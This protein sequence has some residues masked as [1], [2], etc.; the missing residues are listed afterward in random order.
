MGGR[1]Y[2]CGRCGRRAAAIVLAWH[3]LRL[4]SGKDRNTLRNRPC[5]II[6]SVVRAMEKG[7][8]VDAAPP[9]S[10]GERCR[11]TVRLKR[12]HGTVNAHGFDTEAWLLE[13]GLRATGYVRKDDGNSTTRRVR[14]RPSDWVERARERI[15]TRTR[16]R[17][18]A[19]LPDAQ[20]TGV[21]VALTVGD[22]R[23]IPE[24]Q[25]KVFSRTGIEIASL[26]ICPQVFI[27]P[28]QSRFN[29]CETMLWDEYCSS[30]SLRA[31]FE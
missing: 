13:N 24:S 7:I 12:P 4:R 23:A 14:R 16:T 26:G 30:A 18:L 25:W 21:I 15:R 10:A 8:E 22:Q 20:N 28:N 27:R 17:T 29:T 19:A 6:V 1:R 11:L 2:R 5:S 31:C 3:A 9:I